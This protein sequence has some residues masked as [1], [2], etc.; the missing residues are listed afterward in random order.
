MKRPLTNEDLFK[1]L[2]NFSPYG[3]LCQSFIVQGL[4]YYCQEVIAEKENLIKS[5]EDMMIEGKIPILSNKTWVAIAEDI[6]ER[7]DMFYDEKSI[8]KLKYE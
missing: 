3:G 7:M 2:L 8:K 1:N 5:E 4:R 6:A